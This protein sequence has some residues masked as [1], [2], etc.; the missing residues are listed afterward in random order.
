MW[1]PLVFSLVL[2][3]PVCHRVE[4]MQS[5]SL[6]D[7]LF[8]LSN[9]CLRFLDV[10]SW[11]DHFFLMLKIPNNILLYECTNVYLVIYLLKDI[12]VASILWWWWIKLLQ[13]STYIAES[14]GET[15][16]LKKNLP[17]CLSNWLYHY[18]F[19]PAM[20]VYMFSRIW[21]GHFL[22]V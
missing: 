15:I 13:L 8:S 16:T 21:Y 6:S 1:Q 10:F 11:L 9:M 5:V 18:A 17:I 22:K 2:Y 14:C 12:L 3:F 20:L 4:I 19:N 7:C